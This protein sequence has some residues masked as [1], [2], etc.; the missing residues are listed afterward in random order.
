MRRPDPTRSDAFVGE[1]LA[2]DGNIKA[3]TGSRRGYYSFELINTS[4]ESAELWP[5][6]SGAGAFCNDW[7]VGTAPSPPFFGMAFCSS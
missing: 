5:G 6:M 7:L 3:A 1:L 2:V 4:L